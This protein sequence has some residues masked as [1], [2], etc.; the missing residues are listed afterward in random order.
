MKCEVCAK[1]M[2]EG[3]TLW[4]QNAKGEIG[5]WRCTACNKLPRDPEI[6]EIVEAVTG[7]SE[8]PNT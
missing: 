5:I 2:P 8:E 3:V 7:Q 1:G 4:R 6:V